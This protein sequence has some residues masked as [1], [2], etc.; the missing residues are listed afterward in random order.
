MFTDKDFL[1]G[2][3]EALKLTTNVKNNEAYALTDRFQRRYF[4]KEI[5][6]YK[7]FLIKVSE[8]LKK[9]NL[10]N[11]LEYSFLLSYLIHNGYLS[12]NKQY[13]NKKKFELAKYHGINI[14]NGNGV[15]RHF[16]G[17]HKDIFDLLNMYYEKFYCYSPNVII[18]ETTVANHVISLIDYNG[19]L[20]GIDIANRDEVFYFGNKFELYRL[21]ALSKR[22]LKYK[23]CSDYILTDKDYEDVISSIERYDV[24]SK[25][26]HISLQEL[27]DIR[28]KT[29]QTF[30]ENLELFED[31]HNET[32]ELK[33]DISL[34]V[35]S[36]ALAISKKHNLPPKDGFLDF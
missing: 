33:S 18:P 20:H 10:S 31:F 17:I 6:E 1:E 26:Q 36:K 35:R 19:T 4:K 15:C 21:S 11:S 29:I 12:Y 5:E 7:L 16:A 13:I 8:L 32:K 24:E 34:G 14:V 27:K 22:K 25:K 23:P 2:D 3:E 30:S 28:S 9:L